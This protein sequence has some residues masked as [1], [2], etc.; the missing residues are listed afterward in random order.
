MD[1]ASRSL[2]V[3]Q[4]FTEQVRCWFTLWFTLCGLPAR[5]PLVRP[6]A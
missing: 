3:H 4:A 2:L 6:M 5:P 1:T